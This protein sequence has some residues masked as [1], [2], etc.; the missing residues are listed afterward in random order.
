MGGGVE[1]TVLEVVVRVAVPGRWMAEPADCYV[2]DVDWQRKT[3]EVVQ[4]GHLAGI[5]GPV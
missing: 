2:R 3:P 4:S 5:W 1:E